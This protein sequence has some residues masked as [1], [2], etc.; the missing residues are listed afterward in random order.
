MI[1]VEK[2]IY[3]HINGLCGHGFSYLVFGMDPAYYI[4]KTLPTQRQINRTTTQQGFSKDQIVKP[5]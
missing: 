4:L 2:A 5:T 3:Y 1:K